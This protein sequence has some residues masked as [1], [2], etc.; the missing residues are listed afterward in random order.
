MAGD[1]I[2]AVEDGVRASHLHHHGRAKPGARGLHHRRAVASDNHWLVGRSH[3]S[4]SP[5][6][7]HVVNGTK[8]LY[9][10]SPAVISVVSDRGGD[11]E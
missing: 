5:C 10:W 1:A 3:P 8:S 4:A 2:P 7:L 9:A 6:S 11:V